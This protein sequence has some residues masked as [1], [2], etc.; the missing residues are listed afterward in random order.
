MWFG[1]GCT[2]APIR[3]DGTYPTMIWLKPDGWDWVH[4]LLKGTSKDLG[5]SSVMVVLISNFGGVEM[6]ATGINE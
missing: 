6:N 5:L 4:R 1:G 2:H 3:C